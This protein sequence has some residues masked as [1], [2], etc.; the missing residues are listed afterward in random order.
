MRG[1]K[2]RG[3]RRMMEAIGLLPIRLRYAKQSDG[4]Y[5]PSFD[6][7][8]TTNSSPLRMYFRNVVTLRWPVW[9]MIT[10]SGTPARVAVV[11]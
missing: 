4:D 10:S 2:L 5:K 1:G 7:P 9:R 6:A 8:L 11:T 3:G